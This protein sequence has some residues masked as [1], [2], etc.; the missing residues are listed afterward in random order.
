LIL[1]FHLRQNSV[2]CRT[3]QCSAVLIITE[4]YLLY[5][6]L[7]IK[8]LVHTSVLSYWYSPAQFY[9]VSL[10]VQTCYVTATSSSFFVIHLIKKFLAGYGSERF[11]TVIAK[12]LSSGPYSETY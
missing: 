4:S 7:I 6:Y 2:C 5:M 10:S 11:I 12:C 3:K 8:Q 1:R 9:T